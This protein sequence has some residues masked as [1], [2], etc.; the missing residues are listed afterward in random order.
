M[1]MA[2]G[3]HDCATV[4]LSPAVRLSRR[5][6]VVLTCK[7]MTIRQYLMLMM[8]G[9]AFAWSAVILIMT[10]IEPT[11]TQPV[12]MVVFFASLF[13]ALTG[14]F[15]VLGFVSR[16][17]VLRKG[18]RLSHQVAVS[19]RQ[20]AILSL[21]LVAALFLQ[22][23]SMLTWWNAFLAVALATVLES[24]FITAKRSEVRKV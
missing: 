10:M 4:L 13:L 2:A 15:S 20:A 24:F 1:N 9:T 23:K 21:F 5:P 8:L 14:T 11:G 12:V 22:S 19:F 16:I 6:A 3:Q 17:A 7:R 18:F